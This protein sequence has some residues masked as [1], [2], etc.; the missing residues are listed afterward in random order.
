MRRILIETNLK[1]GGIEKFIVNLMKY[2]SPKEC[3]LHFA[4]PYAADHEEFY[5]PFVKEWGAIVHKLGGEEEASAYNKKSIINKRRAFFRLLRNEKFDVCYINVGGNGAVSIIETYMALMKKIPIILVHCHTSN[6][7]EAK[8]QNNSFLKKELH[9]LFRWFWP[10]K[11]VKYLACSELAAQWL[12]PRIAMKKGYEFIPCG[13]ETKK[14]SYD[15]SLRNQMRKKYGVKDEFVIL[16]IGRLSTQKNHVF[17]LKIFN[18]IVKIRPE[19]RL[20]LVGEGEL[21]ETIRTMINQLGLQDS[22]IMTG[23]VYDVSSYYSMADV[24]LFPSLY[25]GLGIVL[26]EAQANGLPILAS[27]VVPKEVKVTESLRFASLAENEKLWAERV[28]KL[29]G[30]DRHKYAV[31]D[32]KERGFDVS[33]VSKQMRALLGL[34]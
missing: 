4:V 14:F 8:V 26:L 13:I 7:T 34:D 27:D 31:H 30:M 15:N 2:I 22:V 29:S 24:F 28:V 12:F 18:E 32:I 21:E 19:S 6:I 10:E 25:E 5:E 11:N 33:D 9:H 1:S 23:A 17:L 3:E 20:V 16:N